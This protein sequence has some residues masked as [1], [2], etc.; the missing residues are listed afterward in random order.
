LAAPPENRPFQA[1]GEF[2]RMFGPEGAAGRPTPARDGPPPPLNTSSRI[3]SAS[4][5]FGD[6]AEL[7][8]IAA[9]ALSGGQPADSAPGEYTKFFDAPKTPQ[10]PP[11]PA[12]PA[13]PLPEAVPAKKSN[14]DLIVI[15]VSVTVL[16]ALIVMAILLRK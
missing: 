3:S 12:A 4:G 7:A 5:M 6:P 9:Q 14:R 15:V 8:K 13:A 2:T 16:V 10:E 11:K 1:A